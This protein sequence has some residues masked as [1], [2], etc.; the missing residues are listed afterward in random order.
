MISQMEARHTRT[1]VVVI[2]VVDLVVG[3]ELMGLMGLRRG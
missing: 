3:E 1:E 2:G